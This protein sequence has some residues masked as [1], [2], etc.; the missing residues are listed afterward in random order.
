MTIPPDFDFT[1]RDLR[2]RSFA[3]QCLNGANFSRADLRGCNF[4]DSQL[5]GAN[6]TEAQ[7]G[8]SLR[9][10]LHLSGVALGVVGVMGDALLRLIFG[11]LGQIPEN[12]KWSFVLLLFAVLTTTGAA[13]TLHT[14]TKNP[15][16]RWSGQLSGILAGALMG[17]F[18]GGQ[19][20]NNNASAALLGMVLGGI[21]VGLIQV[22]VHRP[23]V[24]IATATAAL[25]MTYGA[26]F[27]LSA[28]ASIY[29]STAH[30]GLGSCFSL[31]TI[32]YLGSS[33]LAVRQIQTAVQQ[34]V[35][36]SFRGANLTQANFDRVTLQNADFSHTVGYNRYNH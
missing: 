8:L 1:Q 25:L 19:L 12:G 36:T 17:F 30:W 6:F 16:G 24:A 15:I 11:T 3:G 14:F 7:V 31:G 33:L 34:T 35:G 21:L 23:V 28:T 20:T 10:I 22:Q 9:Q 2:D 29:L 27:L 26:T 5:V 32:A 18:Y 4:R 13:V